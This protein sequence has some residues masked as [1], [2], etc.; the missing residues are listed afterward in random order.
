MFF[1]LFDELF[2]RGCPCGRHEAKKTSNTCKIHTHNNSNSSQD[3]CK[4]TRRQKICRDWNE[5]RCCVKGSLNSPVFFFATSW[6]WEISFSSSSW[7]S[8]IF[9]NQKYELLR[10]TKRP[11]PLRG[12]AK[13]LVWRAS[14]IHQD[15]RI[16]VHWNRDHLGRFVAPGTKCLFQFSGQ[17]T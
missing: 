10:A 14:C 12:L 4:T 9:F 1:S 6:Y 16:K 2:A 3:T 5:S 8:Q 11:L 7:Q 13:G 15:R 17:F